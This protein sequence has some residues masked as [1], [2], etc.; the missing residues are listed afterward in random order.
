MYKIVKSARI[1]IASWV[2]PQGSTVKV[3]DNEMRESLR[4]VYN[5]WPDL[6]HEDDCR[7]ESC[8]W[9]A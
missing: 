7:C 9:S 1:R 8:R 3:Q 5:P 6:P 4:D 2:L